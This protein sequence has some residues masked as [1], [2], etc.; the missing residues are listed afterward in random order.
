MIPTLVFDIETIPDV[1][2]LRRVHSLPSELND[3]DVTRATGLGHSGLLY[4]I[5][6]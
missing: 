3:A 2:G 6:R 4:R 1:A 5:R